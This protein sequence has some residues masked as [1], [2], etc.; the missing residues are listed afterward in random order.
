MKLMFLRHLKMGIK[1]NHVIKSTVWSKE[2]RCGNYRDRCEIKFEHYYNS[3]SDWHI[4]TVLWTPTEIEVYVD[5]NYRSQITRFFKYNIFNQG[6]GPR[7][8][9][10]LN[11]GDKYKEL[12]TFPT[13]ENYTMQV[14]LSSFLREGLQPSGSPEMIVDY[15]K[16][17]QVK[18]CMNNTIN[19]CGLFLTNN[20]P[21]ASNTFVGNTVNF[22]QNNCGWLLKDHTAPCCYD[23]NLDRVVFAVASNEVNLLPGFEV[24]MGPYFSAEIKPCNNN[25]NSRNLN[26]NEIPEYDND[27]LVYINPLSNQSIETSDSEDISIEEMFHPE[28]D[29]FVPSDGILLFPNPAENWISVKTPVEHGF[30]KI[31]TLDGKV[32][33]SGEIDRYTSTIDIKDLSLNSLYVFVFIFNEGQYAQRFSK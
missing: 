22:S 1:K 5:H 31:V 27:S 14:I 28:N 12:R 32:I 16:V 8:C 24:E 15:V 18:E 19:N 26:P 7:Q 2:S 21:N 30:Y 4:Y 6:Y 3:L 20:A 11:S 17:W 10:S 33:K 13:A 9:T 23:E 25:W 29:E